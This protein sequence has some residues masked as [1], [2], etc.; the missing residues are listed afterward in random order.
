ML[1]FFFFWV[2]EWGR[3]ETGGLL[4]LLPCFVVDTSDPVT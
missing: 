4:Y 1:F 3:R 2:C